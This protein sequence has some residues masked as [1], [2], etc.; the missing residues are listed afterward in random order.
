LRDGDT[1][2]VLFGARWYDSELGRWMSKDPIRFDSGQAN[3]YLYVDGDPVGLIDPSGLKWWIDAGTWL[4]Q[5]G[6]FDFIVGWGDTVSW[7]IGAV[8]RKN[9]SDL[10]EYV[11]YGTAYN[12]GVA[13]GIATDIC[14]G[15]GAATGVEVTA[16]AYAHGGGGVNLLRNQER[17][18]AI[19]WHAFKLSGKWVNRPHV[20]VGK[21]KS[22]M[23]KHW[24]WQKKG[25]GGL[26]LPWD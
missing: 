26:R 8:V 18:F 17:I 20:H 24:P 7:G 12:V 11:D 1:G 16:G 10:D 23:K 13:A 14:L 19:D 2:L 21:T 6:V 25:G 9:I 15:Y 5:H 4:E 22:Q 3:L